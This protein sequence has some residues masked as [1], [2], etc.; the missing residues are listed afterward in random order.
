MLLLEM[1]L[2]DSSARA[3]LDPVATALIASGSAQRLRACLN[4]RRLGAVL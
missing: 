4:R 2:R 3:E 1:S